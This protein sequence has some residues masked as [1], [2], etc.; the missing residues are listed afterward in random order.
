MI[1]RA[2]SFFALIYA[3]GFLWF[4]VV[5]GIPPF[6]QVVTRLPVFESGHNTRLII[7]TMMAEV[8]KSPCLANISN[9]RTLPWANTS[10]ASLPISQR[11]TSNS[12]MCRS[13]KI[14]PDWGTYSSGG[15]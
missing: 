5:L 4:A 10:S 3:F 13:R 9:F 2:L 7:L 8:S 11:S 14:P 1:G 6:L 15:G 12:W